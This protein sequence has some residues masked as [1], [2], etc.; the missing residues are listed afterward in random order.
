[1]RNKKKSEWDRMKKEEG[2]GKGIKDGRQVSRGKTKRAT[3][4]KKS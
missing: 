3:K 1:M 4:D 2:R